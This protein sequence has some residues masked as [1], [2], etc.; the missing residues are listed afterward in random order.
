MFIDVLYIECEKGKKKNQEN[1]SK[2]TYAHIVYTEKDCD[3]LTYLSSRQGRCPMTK[4]T[5]TVLTTSKI[6]S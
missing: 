5:A 6:L 1:E 4:K 2:R 3:L